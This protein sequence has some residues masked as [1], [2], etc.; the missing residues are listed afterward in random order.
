M[1]GLITIRLGTHMFSVAMAVRMRA[2]CTPQLKI[3]FST[4]LRLARGFVAEPSR[5]NSAAIPVCPPAS[6]SLLMVRKKAFKPG[7]LTGTFWSETSRL[8][9]S[10][11]PV[12]QPAILLT[13]TWA[14]AS[15]P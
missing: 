3:R 9:S 11:R 4:N 14:L 12:R 1:V 2:P 5:V 8:R 6:M 15:L 7:L 13:P 10:N